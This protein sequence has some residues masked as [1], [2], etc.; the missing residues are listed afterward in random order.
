MSFVCVSEAKV[1]VS[2]LSK[3]KQRYLCLLCVSEAKV[4]VSFVCK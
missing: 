1:L 4:L 3:M 2:F